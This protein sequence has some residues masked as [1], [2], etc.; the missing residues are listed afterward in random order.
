MVASRQSISCPS[1]QTSRVGPSAV[2]MYRSFPGEG[3]VSGCTAFGTHMLYPARI[4]PARPTPVAQPRISSNI[5]MIRHPDAGRRTAD[6]E[7]PACD[8]ASLISHGGNGGNGGTQICDE[9]L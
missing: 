7:N 2:L 1:R 6:S 9:F 8:P 5:A 4:A 3:R